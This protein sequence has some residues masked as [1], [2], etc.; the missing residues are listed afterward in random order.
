MG[1]QGQ[2][3]RVGSP[4]SQV[5]ENMAIATASDRNLDTKELDLLEGKRGDQRSARRGMSNLGKVDSGPEAPYQGQGLVDVIV[6]TMG[7]PGII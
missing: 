5:T 4:K 2:G 1:E 3:K 7:I 6:S